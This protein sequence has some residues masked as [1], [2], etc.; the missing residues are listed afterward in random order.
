M[1]WAKC[2]LCVTVIAAQMTVAGCSSGNRVSTEMD[3]YNEKTDYQYQFDSHDNEIRHNMTTDEDGNLYYMSGY[4]IYMYDAATGINTPLCNKQNCLHDKE[5]DESKIKECNAYFPYMDSTNIR[6]DSIAYENGYIFATYTSM[7]NQTSDAGKLWRKTIIRIKKDG[8][9]RE[10]VHTFTKSIQNEIIHRGYYYYTS[11]VFDENN[12]ETFSV[13]SYPLDGKGGEKTIYTAPDEENG[14]EMRYNGI[15]GYTAYG[16]HLYFQVHGVKGEKVTTIRYYCVDLNTNKVSELKTGDMAET[17]I[18][19]S[20]TFF[21]DKIIFDVIDDSKVQA[22][23]DDDDTFQEEVYTADL[24]GTNIKKAPITVTYGYNMYSD[25]DHL[26]ISDDNIHV[27][28]NI[29][30]SDEEPDGKAKFDVY[31]KNFNLVDTF[32]ENVKKEYENL[33]NHIGY[34]VPLGPADTSYYVKRNFEEGTAELYGGS[35][36]VIGN[37]NRKQFPRKR[38][39][40]IDQSQAVKDYLKD[41]T[42][43]SYLIR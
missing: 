3:T 34:Y 2:I 8:S 23:N 17:D 36:K 21:N 41:P 24:N 27:V 9:S 19:Y 42:N 15:Q 35:K 31:D 5:T 43:A 39:A 26:I 22:L 13:C 12:K 25:G 38:L 32:T 7:D 40:V 30:N 1:K 4:Y 18:I 28:D 16:N 20:L 33:S 6:D 37:I 10:K 11:D 14:E 29:I